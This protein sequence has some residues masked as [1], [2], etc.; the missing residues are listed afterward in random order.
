MESIS[1]LQLLSAPEQRELLSFANTSPYPSKTVHALFAE[2]AARTPEQVALVCQDQCLTYRELNQQANQLARVLRNQGVGPNVLVG[3][4]LEPSFEMY[5]GILGILKAGG[6]YLPI[7]PEY[8]DSRK[9]YLIQNADLQLLLTSRPAGPGV[10]AEWIDLTDRQLYRETAPESA[11]R[12]QA[13]DL[14]Y[15]IYTS[16]STGDPKGVLISHRSVVNYVFWR[17]KTYQLSAAD[18]T[19]QLVPFSFDGFAANCYGSLLSGGTL[20]IGGSIVEACQLIS[21]HQ[22]TNLSLVPSVYREILQKAT[23]ATCKSLRFVVLGGEKADVE[24][25]ALSQSLH[26]GLTLI[27]EYGPTENT[28]A[29]TAYLGLTGETLAVIGAPLSNQQTY[30]MD[31]HQH[32]VPVGNPGELC[33]SGAGLALGYLNSPELTAEKFV[34]Y[35]VFRSQYSGVRE[36]FAGVEK[37]CRLSTLN[38]QLSTVNCQLPNDCQLSTKRIYR[39][40]DI[41]TRLPDG[42]LEFLGRMD[43]QV[44]LNGH[45]IELYEI[46]IKLMRHPAVQTALIVVDDAQN[47]CAYYVAR[48]KVT[49]PELR[50]YLANELPNY[51]IPQYYLELAAIPVLP[52]GKVDF[53]ALPKAGL[54]S[55]HRDFEPPC[56]EIEAKL[57][58]VWAETLD[59]ERVGINDDFFELGGNS[60]AIL[61]ILAGIFSD[62]WQLKIQDFYQFHTIK[63]LAESITLAATH[64]TTLLEKGETVAAAP[65]TGLPGAQSLDCSV[66][67]S[68]RRLLLTGVTGFLGMHLLF[69][70]LK[71]DNLQIYILV[72]GADAESRLFD[73]IHFYFPQTDV[74]IF[75]QRVTVVNGDIAQERLG[76]T[77]SAYEELGRQIDAVVHTAALVKHFGDYQEFYKINVLGTEHVLRFVRDKYLV[78]ISTT[79]VS[80]NFLKQKFQDRHFNERTL[81]IGQ[82]FD[83]NYYM[84][85]KFAAEQMV[86]HQL[87]S[88]LDG[89]VIRIGNLTGRFTDGV[90]QRNIAHNKFYGVLKT[91]LELSLIPES[92]TRLDIEFSPVDLTSRGIV[93]LFLLQNNTGRTFHLFNHQYLDLNTFIALV[94]E[95]GHRIT[96][97]DDPAF[98][99]YI[100]ELTRDHHRH[101]TLYGII[102]DFEDGRLNYSPSVIIDSAYT[103][104]IL[105]QLDFVWPQIELSYLQKVIDHMKTVKY[106]NV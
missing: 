87:Q 11:D 106:V 18:V 51:M 77:R 89:T 91:I 5:V 62:H 94:A 10:K 38:C 15:V 16:G 96:V 54:S 97:C 40:G 59:L 35:S 74:L 25:I 79:S 105:Q 7:D 46:K 31:Q 17:I 2:Q 4:M 102:N 81:A 72:R 37:N 3:L 84:Q 88:G 58:A 44:K 49:A 68:P 8:P 67:R 41:V 27:N 20:V 95:I 60:F 93:K 14:V 21:K 86:A 19:L 56:N 76:L 80:G 50:A 85:T 61:K 103:I 101:K 82:E 45:R 63:E 33:V 65:A 69:E 36:Q 57:S 29:S 34:Q 24:T 78:Y 98:Y 90:F 71:I 43:H 55:R 75:R 1:E 23:A 92:L 42:N 39:T 64:E 30:V 28:I 100:Q 52:S 66:K 73:L 32:L 48:E 70:L 47:L 6:A 13:A 83:G 104:G 22:V 12:N 26:P 99:N 9:N 53:Q